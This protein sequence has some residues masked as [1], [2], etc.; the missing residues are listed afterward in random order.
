MNVTVENLA[1]CKKLVRVEVDVQK[2]QEAFE[3]V[4]RDFQRKAIFPG[5]RPGKV[6]REI[7]ARRFEKEIEG[8]V[9]EKLINDAY[10]KA[11]EGQKLDVVAKPDIEEIQFGR[12]RPLQF[13]ATVETAPEFELPEYKGLPA[14]VET[15]AV[16]EAD[17]ERALEVLRGQRVSYRTVDRPLAS[18]DVAVVNYAG[19]CEGKPITETAPTAMGL[20]EKKGFWI[21]VGNNSFIRGFGEQLL[22]AKAGEKRT[23]TVE[24]PADFVTPQLAGKRGVYEVEVA[25]VKEKVLPPLDDELA[26]AYEAQSLEKLRQGVRRDLENE[27]SL[28]R[29]NSIR[30]QLV[31]SL[32]GRVQFELPE[33]SVA[34]ETRHRI[35]N[36]VNANQRRGASREQIEQHKDRI[37]SAATQDARER[38]KL[39]FLIRRIAEK[40]DVKVS[41]DEIGRRVAQI[42]VT[43][44][45][46]MEK[47]VKD[48]KERNAFIEIYDQ[49]MTEKVMDLLERNAQLIEAP[50]GSTPDFQT[51]PS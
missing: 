1:P 17:V 40:E 42:A 36:I 32:M 34:D 49:V 47:L 22:G 46:P 15:R 16:S 14:R 35:Y 6:P 11:V 33:S 18:G 37:A 3:A 50:P 51:N 27:L 12:G 10:K 41:Q 44:Q 9:K 23:V 20:T 30:N 21:E 4:T 7:V 43:N 13:A 39:A 2:V 31:Q 5:F 25:E 29:S 45:I 24:F 8:E 28:K 38:V 19:Q 48:L 26:K